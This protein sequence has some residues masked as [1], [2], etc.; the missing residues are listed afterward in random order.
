MSQVGTYTFL[1]ENHPAVQVAL[2]SLY[3]L[4]MGAGPVLL[5]VFA[6][7][8]RREALGRPVSLFWRVSPAIYAVAQTL[9]T[10]ATQAAS[11]TFTTLPVIGDGFLAGIVL[12]WL[13]FALA[14]AVLLL[15]WREAVGAERTRFG[16]LFVALCLLFLSGSGLGFYINLTGND[17][18]LRN[19]VAVASHLCA[20][21]GIAAFLYASLRHKI[22]DLGFAVNRTLVYGVLSTVLLFGFWFCEWG[23]EDIIPAETR[24]AN[25]LISAGIA[26]A[27]FLAFH[28]I[29]DWV[30]KAIEHLF[31]RAWRDNEARLKRFLKDAAF[32][33]R[34]EALKEAAVTEFRRFAG[35]TEAALYRVE[36]AAA[37]LSA[38]AVTGLPPSLN[39]D[40]PALVRLRADREPLDGALAEG[41]GAALI[42]PIVQR[43]EVIGLF[44]L[45][46][47]PS[48]EVFRPDERVLLAEA[49]HRIGLD[50][51]LLEV[52]RLEIEAVEQR[53]RADL[54]EQQM[55]KALA[56]GAA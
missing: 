33:N 32:I 35:G 27:I 50:L 20:L 47:K 53:R 28:H 36:P 25:I 41:L 30:E 18:S 11:L 10:V 3:Q 24:E 1:W 26:F 29:R 45:G 44:A 2:S 16:F 6:V 9:L 40:A 43:S 17:F 49:A 48:G 39:A 14:F 38:G 37:T 56:V 51:H 55:Q 8:M 13:G 5:L 42:L 31:F 15:G 7:L 21:G 4:I 34:A 46:P 19:P 54:L 23:L 22:V 52:E 12:Q